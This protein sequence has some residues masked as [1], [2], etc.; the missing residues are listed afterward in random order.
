MPPLSRSNRM[1]ALPR[2]GSKPRKETMGSG[3]Q[4][5]HDRTEKG[6]PQR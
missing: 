6:H 3:K 2:Q 1:F 5:T 4:E